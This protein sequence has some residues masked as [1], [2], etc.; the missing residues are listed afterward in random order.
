MK[1][2]IKITSFEIKSILADLTHAIELVNMPCL[3]IVEKS[4][5]GITWKGKGLS[6]N[7]INV[8]KNKLTHYYNST[9]FGHTFGLTS[10]YIILRDI[11]RLYSVNPE[12]CLDPDEI[13][14]LKPY[15]VNRN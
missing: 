12:M 5:C 9:F 6:T 7:K 11:V 1:T 3:Q 2:N 4:F 15:L 13:K 14:V 8:D 10:S